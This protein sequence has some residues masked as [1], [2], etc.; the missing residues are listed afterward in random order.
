V[1]RHLVSD[2]P[3]RAFLSGGID[4]P[5]IVAKAQASK[6]GNFMAFTVGTA[7]DRSDES[8][9]A[10]AYADELGVKHTV[11]HFTPDTAANM[12]DEV[13]A[14]CGEPF[15]DYSVFP[16]MFACKLAS[17]QWNR[18]LIGRTIAT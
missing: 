12:L 3:L 2:V 13:V 11:E 10:M 14:A 8:L 4:S 6:S 1:R 7:G 16:T 18:Q 9:D 17:S 15:A 5:L